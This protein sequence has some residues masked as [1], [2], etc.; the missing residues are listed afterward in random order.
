MGTDVSGLRLGVVGLALVII[1]F[2]LGPL[3]EI[4][5]FQVIACTLGRKGQ[6]ADFE[7]LGIVDYILLA[8]LYL[9]STD[10]TYR[11]EIEMA[12]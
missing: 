11:V 4:D 10:L 8:K 5:V 12:T 6:N 1:F 3:V 7:L 2:T 9:I